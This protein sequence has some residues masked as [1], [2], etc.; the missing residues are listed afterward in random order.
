MNCKSANQH[1]TNGIRSATFWAGV[2]ASHCPITCPKRRIPGTLCEMCHEY[3]E[4]DS[5]LLTENNLKYIMY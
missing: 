5:G 4:N 2:N 1:I 3:K